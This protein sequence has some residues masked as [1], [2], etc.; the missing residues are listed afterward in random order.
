M[1]SVR[2][3]LLKSEDGIALLTVLIVL[4]VLM[5][6]VPALMLA[7]TTEGNMSVRF[8]NRTQAYYLARSGAEMA[9]QWLQE[10]DYNVESKSYIYGSL[11][12]MQMTSHA[13]G[14]AH[15]V[16]VT[17]EKT[18]NQI[19]IISK[20]E[21]GNTAENVTL[22]LTEHITFKPMEFNNAIFSVGTGT[23]GEPA[24]TM[25]GSAKI[26]GDVGTNASLEE[27]IKRLGTAEIEGDFYSLIEIDLEGLEEWDP[28]K[29]YSKGNN[30]KYNGKRYTAK[31]WTR[32]NQ[33]DISNAWESFMPFVTG[34][35][36]VLPGIVE[37]P[38]PVFPDFPEME[39]P[40][41]SLTIQGGP[42]ND[43]TITEDGLYDSIIIRSNRT[44]TIDLGGGERIIRVT[45]LDIQQ[46]HIKLQNAGDNGRLIL[47][48][49]ESFSLL[50]SSTVND[51][52]QIKHVM[53]YY[54]GNAE[55]QF[56]GNTRFVGSL[57]AE[58]ANI[59][60]AGSNGVTGHIITGGDTVLITGA[61]DMN[62]RLFYAPN[63]HVTIG[64]SG[65]L[66]GSLVAKRTTLEGNARVYFDDIEMDSFP[67]EV[68]PEGY[69]GGDGGDGPGG[70]DGWQ[71]LWR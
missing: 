17:M 65:S 56:G 19:E 66:S 54:K 11:D 4:M 30:V 21:T 24:I 23:S 26:V 63:A 12:G 57:F 46:G 61:A 58:T 52:G 35:T 8:S 14:E 55:P 16:E 49:E 71:I 36:M 25:S 1:F 43:V 60:I 37:Y 70:A 53:M 22:L 13:P 20:G 50:G 40:S 59:T 32:G 42:A 34:E 69:G 62:T 27:A 9:Y 2:I 41:I 39:G 44:L 68:F 28:G 31:W 51:A 67:Q 47:Y 29:A 38:E 10:N 6:L 3:P 45:N 15:P 64:G 48:V 5:L 18:G 33:P 7:F